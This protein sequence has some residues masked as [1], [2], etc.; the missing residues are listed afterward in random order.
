M[1]QSIRH[2]ALAAIALF[3]VTPAM[4]DSDVVEPAEANADTPV[5]AQESAEATP[6]KKAPVERK[7]VFESKPKLTFEQKLARYNENKTYGEQVTCSIER[8]TGSH[9]KE[10]VCMTNADREEY[11]DAARFWF[12]R[13]GGQ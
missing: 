6:E 7:I 8:I 11:R 10:V 13:A 3:A 5:A 2:A 12:Q 4:A 1:N 9:R